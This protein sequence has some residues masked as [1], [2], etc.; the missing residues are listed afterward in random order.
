MNE[1][2][3]VNERSCVECGWTNRQMF[4]ADGDTEICIDC[5]FQAE[6]KVQSEDENEA[7]DDPYEEDKYDYE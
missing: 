6:G 5:K 1:P 7:F 4:P 2:S 3:D